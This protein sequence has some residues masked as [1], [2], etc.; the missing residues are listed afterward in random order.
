MVVRADTV[1]EYGGCVY[2]DSAWYKA[3]VEEE[4][5]EDEG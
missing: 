4:L 2:D 1:V 3:A 5:L